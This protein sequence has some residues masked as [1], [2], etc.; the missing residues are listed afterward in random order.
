MRIGGSSWC[1]YRIAEARNTDKE[2]LQNF[3]CPE[4]NILELMCHDKE[5]LDMEL[6][7]LLVKEKFIGCSLHM[8]VHEYKNDEPS[9]KILKKIE[10]ICNRFAIQNIVIH[11][12]TVVDRFLFQQYKHLPFS[13][14]NMDERKPIGKSIEDIKKILDENPYISFTLDLQHCYVNDPTMQLVRDFHEVLWDKIIQYHIS[15]YHTE[16]LHYPLFKTNQDSII[17][18]LQRTDL[19]IIIESTFDEPWELEQEIAYIKKVIASNEA[20]KQS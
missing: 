3:V 16:Y 18:A 7:P 17:S 4:A 13:I 11:P 12:D 5:H 20:T 8:P 19:P 10:E 1:Y 6:D 14:E 9:H 15:W 2:I